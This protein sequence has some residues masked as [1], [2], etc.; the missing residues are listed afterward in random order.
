MLRLRY[1]SCD[2]CSTKVQYA[3]S[4][5]QILLARPND[6]HFHL[7][8]TSNFGFFTSDKF[9]DQNKKVPIKNTYKKVTF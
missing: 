5:S 4:S 6:G 8:V 9:C 1:G 7:K 3:N 2:L